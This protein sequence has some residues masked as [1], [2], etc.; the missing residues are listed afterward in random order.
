ME[1]TWLG[2]SIRRLGRIGIGF[3]ASVPANA[4]RRSRAT[5]NRAHGDTL[6]TPIHPP[7]SQPTPRTGFMAQKTTIRAGNAR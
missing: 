6:F 4:P 3:V 2:R 5:S 7:T 1:H